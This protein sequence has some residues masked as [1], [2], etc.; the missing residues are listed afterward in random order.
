M[1]WCRVLGRFWLLGRLV[2]RRSRTASFLL[3]AILWS[4][5]ACATPGG[6]GRSR[7]TTCSSPISV[8]GMEA[9]NIY[10]RTASH[11]SVFRDGSAMVLVMC[12]GSLP[13]NLPTIRTGRVGI[14]PVGLR[15]SDP[16]NGSQI[17]AAVF[18]P[19]AIGRHLSCRF[20]GTDWHASFPTGRAAT[21]GAC[22]GSG[23]R[24]VRCVACGRIYSI[25]WR[26]K[27]RAKSP[28]SRSTIADVIALP[29]RSGS[30][31][32][33]PGVFVLGM[34]RVGA[35]HNVRLAIG[36]LS[37]G[38]QMQ[39]VRLLLTGISDYRSDSVHFDATL[40]ERSPVVHV[41]CRKPASR[42]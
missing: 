8:K 17:R 11:P 29:H 18:Y 7:S 16:E 4:S 33:V 41:S 34:T 25:E 37:V 38:H 12:I 9:A 3:V 19:P 31:D 27:V 13:N 32:R 30:G 24:S 21:A 1:L 14:D 42:S 15:T 2:S 22:Q 40:P 28:I 36:L 10:P 20:S 39:P 35:H 26:T 23:S 5:S 6:D